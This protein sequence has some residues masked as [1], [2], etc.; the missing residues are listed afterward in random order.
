MY[1]HILTAQRRD[2]YVKDVAFPMT[3]LLATSVACYLYAPPVV[4]LPATV[5]AL[6][7]VACVLFF[8]AMSAAPTIRRALW[9]TLTGRIHKLNP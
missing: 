3:A 8:A 1:R 6:T 2:W 9:R 4:S 5:A 7:V